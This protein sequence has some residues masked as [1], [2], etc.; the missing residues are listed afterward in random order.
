M[1]GLQGIIFPPSAT[2]LV[3]AEFHSLISEQYRKLLS[4]PSSFKEMRLVWQ[5]AAERVGECL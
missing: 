3:P 2:A 1:R 4:P 5:F